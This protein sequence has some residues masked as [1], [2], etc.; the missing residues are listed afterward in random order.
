MVGLSCAMTLLVALLADRPSHPAPAF[1]GR[2]IVF[3]QMSLRNPPG[4]PPS[5]KAAFAAQPSQLAITMTGYLSHA[6]TLLVVLLADRPSHPAPAFAG[7]RIVFEQMSLR[8]PPGHPPSSKAAFAAQPSQLAITMTG[9]L[10]HAM[11]LLVVLLAD[12]PSHPAPAFAGRRIVFEQMSL[13]NPPGHPPSSKAAFAAQPS[14][15]AI[16]MTGY[17]SHAMTLLVVL[18]ADRPSHPAPAFAGRRIVFEQMSL[19]NPPGHP[20]SSKAAFA[21]QPSQLAITMTGYLSHA[22]TLLV[23]LLADRPSHPA[24]AFAGRRILFEQM[25]LRNPPGHPPSSKAAF[26]AQPSQL[27]ITMTGYLSHAM[28]LLVV[29][30][31]DRPSHPA[32]AFAGRSILFEQMSLRNP[33]GHP[34]SS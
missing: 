29:L 11:T 28:T 5:S 8:N 2:R 22:M 17:L 13:R 24:P 15:L 23:A 16:T 25:S 7:R 21:A 20:P 12:R 18:L 34:P 32:P 19:R 33:P 31:A 30:L 27:A 9:Y 14:Q 4:H 1:A 6:M 10:S 26:A 3:E